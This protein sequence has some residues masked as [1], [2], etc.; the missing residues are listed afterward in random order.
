MRTENN[1]VEYKSIQKIRTTEGLRDL[2]ET[3]VCLANAQGGT[4]AIGIDDRTKEPPADQHLDQEEVNKALSRLRDMTYSVGF[5]N[6]TICVHTNGGE[7]IEMSIAPSLKTIATTST[8]KIFRRVADT[9]QPVRGDE[10]IVLAAEKDAFQW[11]LVRRGSSIEDVS[12]DSIT[13]FA[14]DIRNSIKVKESIKDKSDREILEHY[15]L[16]E[17]SAL[18]NLGV[19]WLGTP[20]QRARLAYPIT[21]QYIVY[22]EQEEKIRKEVWNDYSLD[23]KELL[24]DIENRG[25]ELHYFHEIPHG[26]FRKQVRHYP[27]EV[28][29][30]LLVNAFAHKAFTISS[31]ILIEVYPDRLSI[32]NPGG[33]PLGITP[34][35]ILHKRHRRNP[36]MI[37]ILHDLGLMEGEGSGYDMVYE[38]LL[39]DSKALPDIQSDFHEMRVTVFSRIIDESLLI[40]LDYVQQHFTLKQREIITLGI[41]ARHRKILATQLARELQLP[42]EARL[43]EW[44]GRILDMEI[45]VSR[46]NKKGTSYLVNPKLLADSKANLRPSLKTIEPYALQALIEECL[47]EHPGSSITQIY[48]ILR[49]EV[50]RID[51]QRMVYRMVREGKVLKLG[52]AKMSTTY[53]VVKKK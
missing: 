47:K 19:L 9:C 11:E 10:V 17:G 43:R 40:L 3:C 1:I 44:V 52:A 12:P 23:P 4:I 28:I 37:A 34:T 36:H 42:E 14:R 30:E 27:Q 16:V 41:I 51:I 33:L 48:S 45:L 13:S 35:N 7:Y 26:L 22:D 38:K 15:F 5:G 25:V 29:R 21:V 24:L 6:P 32:S 53:S 18:T 49:K 8:G 50:P 39:V 20:H 31:D 46:G 2:A